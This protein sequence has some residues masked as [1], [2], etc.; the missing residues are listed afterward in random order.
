MRRGRRYSL[1]WIL[2]WRG[3]GWRGCR[4]FTH[5]PWRKYV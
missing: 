2:I 5:S 1:I 4:R 3:T